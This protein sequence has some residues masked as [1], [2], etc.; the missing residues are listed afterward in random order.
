MILFIYY[1]F[2]NVFHVF[3]QFLNPQRVVILLRD[4]VL[5]SQLVSLLYTAVAN[6]R[7]HNVGTF[8]YFIIYSL[9]SA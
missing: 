8:L 2:W 3:E 5:N 9:H 6:G 4:C 7:I 1:L